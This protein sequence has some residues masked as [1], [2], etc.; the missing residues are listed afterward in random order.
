MNATTANSEMMKRILDRG[1]VLTSVGGVSFAG[2]WCGYHAEVDWFDP[3]F[4]DLHSCNFTETL[5]KKHPEKAV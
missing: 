2:C 3:K 5:E 4:P 1:M